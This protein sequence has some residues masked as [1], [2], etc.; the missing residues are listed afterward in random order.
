MIRSN[1]IDSTQT[2]ILPIRPQG[3]EG[4][5]RLVVAAVCDGRAPFHFNGLAGAHKAPLQ[6]LHNL[7][8]LEGQ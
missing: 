8:E 5:K 3:V 6:F 7:I 4:V 2:S 1:H